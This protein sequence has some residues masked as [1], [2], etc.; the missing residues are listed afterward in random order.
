MTGPVLEIAVYKIADVDTFDRIQQ[1]T[2]TLAQQLP[3][4]RRWT[5]LSDGPART[6]LVE[7]DDHA[8]A[9]AASKTFMEAAE[10]APFREAITEI[11]AFVHFPLKGKIRFAG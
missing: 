5:H 10:F 11:Q 6:D 9:Q 8:A 1:Q 4:F 7:W 3:G 2:H